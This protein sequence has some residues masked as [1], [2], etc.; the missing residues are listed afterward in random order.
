MA[1][2]YTIPTEAEIDDG[3]HPWA[4]LLYWFPDDIFLRQAGYT[5]H[6]RP[7]RGPVLWRDPWGEIVT[8]QQAMEVAQAAN[9][10]RA[11]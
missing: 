7:R 8:E 4:S 3:P 6:A 1:R 11:E 5:I 10:I 9:E 2:K